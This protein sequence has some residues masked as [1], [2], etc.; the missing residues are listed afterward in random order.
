M[1]VQP[2]TNGASLAGAPQTAAPATVAVP[3]APRP[4][5]VVR[6]EEARDAP[7]GRDRFLEAAERL[8]EAMGDIMQSYGLRFHV[9][10]QTHVVRLQVVD[11]VTGEVIRQVPREA[12]AR[13]AE[14]WDAY[15]GKLVDRQ[16]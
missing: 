5:P 7:A 8:R 6:P 2:L 1:D 9:D 13:F 14:T 15:V 4:A 16:T 3:A 11:H 10:P 12:L